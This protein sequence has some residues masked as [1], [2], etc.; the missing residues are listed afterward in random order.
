MTVFKFKFAIAL[1]HCRWRELATMSSNPPVKRKLFL[2]LKND[3]RFCFTTTR[4][5]EDAPKGSVPSNTKKATAWSLKVFE[6][7]RLERNKQHRWEMSWWYLVCGRSRLAIV[8][9]VFLSYRSKKGRR[10][11][12][13]TAYPQPNSL[14]FTSYYARRQQRRSEHQVAFTMKV[15]DLND[16]ELWTWYQTCKVVN[17]A[18]IRP[19]LCTKI[20]MVAQ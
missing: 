18:Y 3:K 5:I 13:Y 4:H 15:I 9:A 6:T 10:T 20:P 2:K 1:L 14:W 17:M 11:T 7:W 12:V 16:Y 8:V 19:P